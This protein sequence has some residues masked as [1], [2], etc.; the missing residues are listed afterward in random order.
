MFD[1][2]RLKSRS[3]EMWRRVKLV[4]YHNTMWRHNSEDLDLKHPRENLETRIKYFTISFLIPE[5]T[6]IY[7]QTLAENE[8]STNTELVW[9]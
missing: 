3:S 7:L 5:F 8:I 2:K 1:I 9:R 4:A 6:W